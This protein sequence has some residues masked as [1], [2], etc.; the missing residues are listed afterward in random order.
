M[1]RGMP[2]V[3]LIHKYMILMGIWL[4]RGGWGCCVKTTGVGL[5]LHFFT[6]I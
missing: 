2:Y 3:Q 4:C 1:A 5:W 6:I